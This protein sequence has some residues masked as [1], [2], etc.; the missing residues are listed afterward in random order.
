MLWKAFSFT[1]IILVTPIGSAAERDSL[2]EVLRSREASPGAAIFEKHCASCHGGGRLGAPARIVLSSL[3]RT[4]IH[5]ALTTGRM[6]QFGATLS[7]EERTQLV[8]Y[9]KPGESSAESTS[10]Y[11]LVFCERDPNW[12]RAHHAS[13][14]TGWGI[15]LENTRL[16][17]APQA[18][19][20]D[21]DLQHLQLQWVFAYPNVGSATSQPLL[22]GGGLFVGSHDGTIYALD[23]K[24]GCVRWKFSAAAAVLGG[25]VLSPEVPRNSGASTASPMLFF[26]DQL[27]YVYALDATSGTLTWKAKVD[28]HGAAV[29]T[30]TPVLVQDRLYVPVASLEEAEAMDRGYPCCT[31]RGSIVAVEAS[32]GKQIWKRYTIASPATKQATDL[33]GIV[34]YG[35]SGAGVWGSPAVD[36][37][38]RLLYFATGNSYSEPGDSSSNAIFAIEL[39]TGSVRWRTQTIADDNWNLGWALRCQLLAEKDC[40]RLTKAGADVDFSAPPILVRAKDG[41]DIVVA[42]RKDGF[43]VGVAPD[44]GAIQW[45]T[46]ASTD[47]NPYAAM[48]FFGMMV[49]G[50]RVI[51]PSVGGTVPGPNQSSPMPDDGLYALEAFTGKR[52]WSTRVSNHCGK[53]GHCLGVASAPIGFHG[54]AFAGSVDGYVR[55]FDTHSGEVRWSFD[56]AR[57]FTAINGE[58]AKGGAVSR[59]GIMIA[60]GMVYVNSGFRSVPGNVLLA[61]SAARASGHSKSR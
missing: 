9:L 30:A 24:E 2:R 45:S 7:G 38:R 37:R 18:G 23:A 31:F 56:T 48:L 26:G 20:S 43:V 12:F 52:V 16:V 61:F 25:M 21:A 41:R 10:R 32:T 42:G 36:M 55:A 14:G 11:P 50:E 57:E 22:A 59:N 60:E 40:P 1:L 44:T 4:S 51:V 3:P 53:R 5:S 49:D 15:D 29:V 58:L 8:E 46:T 6:R 35:P 54:V 13:V 28:D 47:S 17:S 39:D 33:V 27:A 19:L 34:R